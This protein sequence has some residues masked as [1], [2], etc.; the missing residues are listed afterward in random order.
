M[1]AG[2][3]RFLPPVRLEEEGVAL[4]CL[5]DRRE[6]EE[7]EEEEREGRGGGGG[8]EPEER[9]GRGGGMG[10]LAFDEEDCPKKV[11]ISSSLSPSS[12]ILC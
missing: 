9:E 3:F 11:L 8:R 7:E 5:V 2:F 6:E 12:R 4:D 1:E 10:K